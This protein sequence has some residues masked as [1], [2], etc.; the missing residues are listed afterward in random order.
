MEKPLKYDHL[1]HY[2]VTD[3]GIV[4]NN[5][6]GRIISQSRDSH[7][8]PQVTLTYQQ[9]YSKHQITKKVH[10]IVAEHFL[11]DAANKDDTVN[12]KDMNKCNNVVNNLEWMSRSENTRDARLHGRCGMSTP[13]P[14]IVVTAAGEI[15]FR[16]QKEAAQYLNVNPA[17]VSK[18]LRRGYRVRGLV[19]RR[20]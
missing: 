10:R 16:S 6:T 7:G 4:R 2:S 19:V 18:A 20:K 14:V 8:Y 1:N 9:P 11:P 13:N 12:H 3:Q 15:T 17:I 5:L